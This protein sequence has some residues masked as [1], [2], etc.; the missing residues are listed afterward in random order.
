[1][2]YKLVPTRISDSKDLRCAKIETHPMKNHQ[3]DEKI[4]IFGYS[5][6]DSEIIPESKNQCKKQ[7]LIDF[8]MQNYRFYGNL[9]NIKFHAKIPEND[10]SRHHDY[11]IFHADACVRCCAGSYGFPPH[12]AK[13]SL[14]SM[15]LGQPPAEN[16][17]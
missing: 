14:C 16:Q 12:G 13:H 11:Q 4:K 2:L 7:F 1:M 17:A 10:D 6:N 15:T 3:N 5:Q 9:E 8:F